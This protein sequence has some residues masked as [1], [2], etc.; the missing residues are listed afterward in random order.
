[1]HPITG[2][3]YTH[4]A[5]RPRSNE[6]IRAP[7]LRVIDDEGNNRGVMS[8]E[9]A[10]S[11][12]RERGFDLVEVT[13]KA[14]PPVARILEYGKY[15]YQQQKK[16]RRSKSTK[17]QELKSVQIRVK[18]SEHDLETKVNQIVRFLEKGH[19]VRVHIFLRGREKA[20]Q[21]LA[22]E[23]LEVF[24]KKIPIAYKLLESISKIPTGFSTIITKE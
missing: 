17:S 20:H 3:N 11:L 16:D 14:D 8:R 9:D 5:Q 2:F 12:A 15:I 13:A 23:R 21:E 4:I 24:I 18:T 19:R 1:L 6:Q 7:R 22:R 10:L